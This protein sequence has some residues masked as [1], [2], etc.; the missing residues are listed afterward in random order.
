MSRI[1]FLVTHYQYPDIFIVTSF[2]EGSYYK[3]FFRI[4]IGIYVF[5]HHF[6]LKI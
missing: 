2:I 3:S 4:S 1:F 5:E 6:N